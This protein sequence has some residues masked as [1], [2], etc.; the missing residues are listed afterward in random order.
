[1][2]KL[3]NIE[4]ADSLNIDT[5]GIWWV[6]LK[7]EK[8]LLINKDGVR[9]IPFSELD[10][11]TLDS[12]KKEDDSEDDDIVFKSGTNKV[13]LSSIAECAFAQMEKNE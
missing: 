2:I 1:M 12:I 10:Q 4:K 7:E 11:E 5:N 3:P 9:T 13:N 8:I 6:Y